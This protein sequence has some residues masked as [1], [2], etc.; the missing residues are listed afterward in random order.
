M[1]KIW[2]AKNLA[3]P[4][5][6]LDLEVHAFDCYLYNKAYLDRHA[7]FDLYYEKASTCQKTS[8]H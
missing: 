8:C 2:S 5:C 6:S 7:C 4:V 1:K 3:H